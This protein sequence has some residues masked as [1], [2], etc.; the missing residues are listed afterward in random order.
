MKTV[1]SGA[2][3]CAAP[4]VLPA[5][6]LG[7]DGGIAPSN[8]ITLGVIGVGSRGRHD[9]Q[10][11]LR[12]PDVQFLAI[13]EVQADRRNAAKEWITKDFKVNDISTYRDFRELLD[14]KDI[15]TVLVAT[16]DRWHAHASIYAAQAGK[17]VYSE[18]PCAITID[19]CRQ[20]AASMKRYGTIFQGGTQR[21]SLGNFKFACD[22][23]RN[24]KLGK[25][26]E[27][28][29]AIYYLNVRYDWLPA[30]PQPDREHIDWDLWLGPSP[31]RPYNSDYVIKSQWRAHYDFDSGA[32]HHDWGAHTVDLCQWAVNADGSAPVKYWAEGDRLYGIYENGVKLVMRPDG[33][34]GL[35]NCAVRFEGE[36]GWIETGDSGRIAVF[37]DSLRGELGQDFAT[38]GGRNGGTHGEDP[39]THIRNFFDCVKTREQPTCNA[40]VIC[41]SHI[42][43]HASALSWLLKRELN[44]DPKTDTFL[45]DDQANRMKTRAWREPWI[46]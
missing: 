39:L 23:A 2:V 19:L 46:V 4:V 43:C 34:M 41:S 8:K 33:W 14:R 45:N 24:G 25:L 44:F 13:A 37:P 32:K 1:S 27:V 30:Q 31:W 28:H 40:D 11:M 38:Y 7:L 18:K 21:R 15:D 26:K 42:A 9:L 16:G 5:K 29:A 10:R 3:L 22:L 17:D 36:D 6:V 20:L 12:Q 35:G